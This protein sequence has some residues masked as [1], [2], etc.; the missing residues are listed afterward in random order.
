MKP[1]TRRME[2]MLLDAQP[3]YV[4]LCIQGA[5]WSTTATGLRERGL[6]DPTHPPYGC[7]LTDEGLRVRRELLSR[8]VQALVAGALDAYPRASALTE[9]QRQRV[10]VTTTQR[11]LEA[12][13]QPRDPWLKQDCARAARKA[14]D[15]LVG[16]ATGPRGGQP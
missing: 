5:T 12:G 13:R 3:S 4:G 14:T 10:T 6:V 2:Y 16:G 1:L 11:L 15:E 7:A 9:D 8:H